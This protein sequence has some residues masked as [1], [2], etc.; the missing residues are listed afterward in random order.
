MTAVFRGGAWMLALVGAWSAPGAITVA[1]PAERQKL[2]AEKETYLI[3][4]TVPGR[5]EFL[6]VNGVTTDVYRTGAFLAMVPVKR[7][8]FWR[9]MPT[10]SRRLTRE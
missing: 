8:F 7:V 4:A 2:Q 1:F 6:Y 9:T 3:G 10:P 5:T